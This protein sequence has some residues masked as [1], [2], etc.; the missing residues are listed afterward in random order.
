[1]KTSK[2]YLLAS[3]LGVVAVS[4]II[5][6]GMTFAASPEDSET[7]AQKH[8]EMKVVMENGDYEAWASLMNEKKDMMLERLEKFESSINE[9]T[10]ANMQQ[11]HSLVQ[12]EKFEEA[13]ELAEE[14]DLP[15]G[16][17]AGKHK[18]MG[19]KGPMEKGPWNK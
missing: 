4:L 5:T 18:G 19:Q 7:K 10:F 12:E 16:P 15:F 9:E 17:G 2:K 11:I 14:L 8:E 13:K 3:S 1:M 6:A